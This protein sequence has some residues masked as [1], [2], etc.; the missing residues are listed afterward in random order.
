MEAFEASSSRYFLRTPESTSVLR[1]Q[2]M[3]Q[4]RINK[5]F[6]TLHEVYS[7]NQLHCM[8]GSIWNM[9]KMGITMSHKPGKN[10]AKRS[11]KTIHGKAGSREMV[12]VMACANAIG[13]AIPPHFIMPGQT[14]RALQ[15]YGIENL[16][17][18]S[19][20][21]E[22]KFLVSESGWT[23]DGI[24]RLWFEHTFLPNIGNER[25]EL[26]IFDEDGSHNN[27]EFIEIARANNIVVTEL[28]SHTSNWTQLLDRSFLSP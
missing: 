2:G 17:R 26:L 6:A 11:V 18:E 25:P 14:R 1:H 21:K 9:D 15:G 7:E 13:T 24:P 8:P 10:F 3:T 27:V 4:G 16:P 20:L 5:F 22:A 12:T 28:P 19:Q 23:K